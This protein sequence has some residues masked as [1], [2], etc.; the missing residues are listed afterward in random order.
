MS[1]RKILGS[2]AATLALIQAVPCA[3]AQ[4]TYPSRPIKMILPFA[5]G[6]QSDVVAR[7]I[8]AR[9]STGL[10]QPIVVENLGGAGGMIARL[11]SRVPLRMATPF[12]S[13]T[14]A[15]SRSPPTSRR[16]RR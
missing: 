14:P 8:A 6:G 4:D 2:F 1:S 7:L 11:P 3:L 16:A 5:T 15:R 13:P 9:M 12:F 10:G